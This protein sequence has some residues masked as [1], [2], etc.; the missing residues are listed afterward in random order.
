[1]KLIVALIP[2]AFFVNVAEAGWPKIDGKYI[3]C[4][5][6]KNWTIHLKSE[7]TLYMYVP[8]NITE[9]LKGCKEECKAEKGAEL[10]E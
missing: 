9:L 10:N 2:L 8:L 6:S 1:M 5:K 7:K 3:H 4:P